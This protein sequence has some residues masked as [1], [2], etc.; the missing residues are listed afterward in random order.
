M[1]LEF[2]FPGLAGTGYR[3]T[4][5]ATRKYNCI[6]W[7]VGNDRQWLWP[8]P[9]EDCDWPDEIDREGSLA[10]FAAL[11]MLFGF[12]PCSDHRIE[13]GFERVALFADTDGRPTHAARQLQNGRWTSKLGMAEDIEHDLRAIEGDLYGRVVRIFRRPAPA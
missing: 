13:A 5:P 2:A 10:A 11:F 4:S 8:G 1:S 9:I 12:A 3:I 6:A 7:A